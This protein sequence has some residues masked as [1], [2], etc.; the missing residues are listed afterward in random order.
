[1]KAFPEMQCLQAISRHFLNTSHGK[2]MSLPLIS[3][4]SLS[5]FS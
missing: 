1:M 5:A 2:V 4:N 3:W